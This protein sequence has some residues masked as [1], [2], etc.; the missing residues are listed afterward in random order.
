MSDASPGASIFTN[1]SLAVASPV[2]ATLNRI[3][4]MVPA[5]TSRAGSAPSMTSTVPWKERAGAGGWLSTIYV[6]VIASD[7]IPDLLIIRTLIL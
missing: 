2:L 6:R 3:S 1:T 7:L 5:T 4:K